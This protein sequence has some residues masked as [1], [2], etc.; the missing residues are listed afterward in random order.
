MHLSG[1]HK[2]EFRLAKPK[3][4]FSPAQALA[5]EIF[6]Y[7]GKRLPF[8]RIMREVSRKGIQFVREEFESVKKGDARD[9]L[10]LFLWR[11]SQVKV[12]FNETSETK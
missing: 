10:S 3:R 12:S 4:V 9:K 2:V 8:A 1:F 5:D 6:S 7:F 11:V